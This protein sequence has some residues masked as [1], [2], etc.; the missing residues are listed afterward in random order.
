MTVAANMLEIADIKRKEKRRVDKKLGHF[1]DN[2]KRFVEGTLIYDLR[3]Q[4]KE[5]ELAVSKLNEEK[6]N[7]GSDDT[8]YNCIVSSY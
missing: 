4:L 2:F 3:E 7:C 5:T 8:Q 6:N 1:T